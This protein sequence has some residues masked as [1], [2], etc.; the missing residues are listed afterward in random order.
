MVPLRVDRDVL[1]CAG[2]TVVLDLVQRGILLTVVPAIGVR[3]GN[4]DA[5]RN[6][7][8]ISSWNMSPALYRQGTLGREGD[9]VYGATSL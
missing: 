2:R 7:A 9:A 6:G 5:I 4:L 8:V 1:V 3:V